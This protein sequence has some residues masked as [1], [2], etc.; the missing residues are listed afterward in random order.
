M[1]HAPRNYI[2]RGAI[3][4]TDIGCSSKVLDETSANM[5]AD[6][7]RILAAAGAK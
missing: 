4:H 5:L 2:V 1:M 3:V 7:E 6:V